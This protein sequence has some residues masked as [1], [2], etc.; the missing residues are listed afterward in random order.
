[1][2]R[3]VALVHEENG[4]FGASFPDLP[5]CTT[6]EQDLDRLVSKAAE[7][8]AFHVGGLI[9]DGLDVPEFRSLTSLRGDP[10]FREAA[11]DATILLIDVD[12]PGR[13]VRVNVTMDEG[14][15][16]RIDR[17]AGAAGE[18]RSGFLVAAAKARLADA[19]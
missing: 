9:E 15:L 5:G 2:A 10:D 11:Q 16:R 4:R 18:T 13:T 14:I 7:V 3:L 12:L 1:M 17:A 6:V 19:R 8:A